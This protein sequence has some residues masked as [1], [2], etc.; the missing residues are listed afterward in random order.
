MQPYLFHCGYC[1]PAMWRSNDAHGWDDELS[2]AFFVNANSVEDALAWGC[3]V[4]EAFVAQLF[5][6]AGWTD[7]P[8]WKAAEFARWIEPA[9]EQ[10]YTQAELEQLE[11]VDVG[12]LPDVGRW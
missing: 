3:E 4:A 10:H 2:I 9:P 5:A 12:V 6:D 11:R 1:T 8:S 7:I